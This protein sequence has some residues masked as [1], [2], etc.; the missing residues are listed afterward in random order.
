MPLSIPFHGKELVAFRNTGGML[1]DPIPLW[2]RDGSNPFLH[3]QNG[4]YR[5]LF[6]PRNISGDIHHRHQVLVVDAPAWLGF[7][8]G[9]QL[10]K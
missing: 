6:H 7:F 1:G 4:I 2:Q 5:T 8:G 9:N 10:S 3:L